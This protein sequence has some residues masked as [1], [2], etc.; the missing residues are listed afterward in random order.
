M[1]TVGK[2][3]LPGSK[4]KVP[5]Y[6]ST[7]FSDHSKTCLETFVPSVKVSSATDC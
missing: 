4:L 1:Q 5:A 6:M 2:G 3:L 7:K